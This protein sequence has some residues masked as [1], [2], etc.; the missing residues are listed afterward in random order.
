MASLIDDLIDVLSEECEEYRKL[1]GISGKKMKVIVQQDLDTLQKITAEEQEHTGK[2]INL[3]KKREAVAKDIAMV[4]NQ[5]E[6]NLTVKDI[7]NVLHSQKEVQ[8]R[9]M[10]VHDELKQTLK[11]FSMVNEINKNLI[12]ESLEIVDFNL[13]YLQGM[14][15]A[16]ET[17]NYSKNAVNV[18]PKLDYGVF[19]AK[20]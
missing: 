5:D 10:K 7:I 15:Q 8:E 4:L 17:E 14:Y 19:D 12:R 11:N 20:Q 1:T 6:E 18:S 2:L 9:L 16:P 3:E 13:N